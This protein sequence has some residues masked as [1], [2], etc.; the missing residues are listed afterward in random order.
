ML[1]KIHNRQLNLVEVTSRLRA[2][3]TLIVNYNCLRMQV[4]VINEVRSGR[5]QEIGQ[6]GYSLAVAESVDGTMDRAILELDYGE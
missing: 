6:A 2:V 4:N 1:V 5:S 3:S